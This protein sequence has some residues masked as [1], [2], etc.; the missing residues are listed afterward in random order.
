[1]ADS[2][3]PELVE[4]IPDSSSVSNP[5]QENEKLNIEGNVGSKVPITIVTGFLGSGKTTLLNYILTEQHGKKIAVILNEFG[6]SSGIEKSLSISQDGDL[7]EEWLELKNGCLCCSVK[8]NG[9]KAIENLMQKKG[10][11]DY[12]LLE[13]TG[14]ADPGP[15]ASMFWLDDDLGGDIYLDGIVTLVDAKY[16]QQYLLEEKEDEPINEAVR[17]IA[18]ADRIIINKMD[19]VTPSTLNTV[20]A[21]IRLINSAA[22]ILRTEKS[23]VPL[24]FI[25]D[26]HAYDFKQVLTLN[27]SEP[28]VLGSE[29]QSHHHIEKE[30]RTICLSEFP[31]KTIDIPKFERW[32]QWILWEKTIPI[33]SSDN[34][35]ILRLKG[36]LTPISNPD[37]RIVIQG[38]QELYDLQ[39]APSSS[40][41]E[42]ID[43]KIVIIGKNLDYQKLKQSLWNYMGWS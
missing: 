9:V 10:K 30:V 41:N 22:D 3:I 23:R 31:V 8:D 25:L 15:I 11:F 2:E 32:I 20:Q 40:S 24:N 4:V 19:L 16:I 6:E 38:V 39:Q 18:I 28:N 7:F 17:Q 29:T 33:T 5:V 14:L 21:Q 37:S 13:T 36:I 43:D 12:I 1:M 35:T 42:T 27:N 26:I 34:I